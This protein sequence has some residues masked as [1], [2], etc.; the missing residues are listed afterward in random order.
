M[1][2]ALLV[3]LAIVGCA[4]RD[5][6]LA[7]Q[8]A[9]G[10]VARGKAAIERRACGACHIIPGV[11]GAK[12]T[13]GPSLDH[14]GK[15]AFVAGKPNSVETMIEWVRHPQKVEPG[16]PMPEMGISEQEAKDIA[17]YLYTLR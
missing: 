10:D 13:V 9:G 6:R 8:V 1:R 11:P 16:T 4:R 14:I 7:T 12:A 17:A 5:E 3:V 15:R 2:V